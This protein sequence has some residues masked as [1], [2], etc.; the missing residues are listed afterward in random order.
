M[1]QLDWPPTTST[2]TVDLPVTRLN[3]LPRILSTN[4]DSP[5]SRLTRVHHCSTTQAT[6]KNEAHGGTLSLDALLLALLVLLDGF[7]RHWHLQVS[8]SLHVSMTNTATSHPLRSSENYL[9]FTDIGIRRWKN[10]K[11]FLKRTT[12]GLQDIGS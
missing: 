2:A 4:R 9:D 8:I 10:L 3:P 5:K 12:A 6:A 11:M 7:L 1:A